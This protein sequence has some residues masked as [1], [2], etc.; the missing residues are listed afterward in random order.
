V[1][2]IRDAESW[3]DTVPRCPHWRSAVHIPVAQAFRPEVCSYCD[4]EHDSL[5]RS[6]TQSD[7]TNYG[8]AP[9]MVFGEIGRLVMA[10]WH[11]TPPRTELLA[12]SNFRIARHFDQ[13]QD[14]AY[15]S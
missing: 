15:C 6:R 12:W 10:T 3:L 7:F 1:V 11:D 5:S 4:T 8:N 13:N 2:L 14:A 9:E